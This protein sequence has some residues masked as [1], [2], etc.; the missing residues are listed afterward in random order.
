MACST[1]RYGLGVTNEIG[2]DMVNMKVKK[3]CVMT[4]PYL[5]S[6]KPVQQTLDSLTKNGVDF[7]LYDKVRVEP[8]DKRYTY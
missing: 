5:S 6:M 1:I 8:T 4:D 2:M 3:A 7:E